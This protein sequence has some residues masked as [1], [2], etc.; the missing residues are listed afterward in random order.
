L[1]LWDTATGA[2]TAAPLNTSDSV[3]DAAI[4]PDGRLAAS[5]T[6]DGNLLLSPAIADP[7]QLCDKLTANMSHTQWRDWVS[8]GI[9][10]IA[11]C[12]GLPIP[13]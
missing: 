9:D 7:G 1:R 2:P 11:V 3:T 4:S 13:A 6:L 10:Y 12:P 5:T 8:P